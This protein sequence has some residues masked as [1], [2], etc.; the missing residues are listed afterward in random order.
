MAGYCYAPQI[1]LG[2]SS[3][4]FFPPTFVGVS[5]KQKLSIKNESRIPLEVEWKVPQKY[6]LEVIFESQ[7]AYLLPNEEQKIVATFTP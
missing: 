7:K 5:S 4:L 1:A 3:K 2:N 6:K